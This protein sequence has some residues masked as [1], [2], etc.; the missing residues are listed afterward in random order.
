MK[1]GLKEY[2][3][4]KPKETYTVATYA[5]MKRGLKG[6]EI[7][8]Q[9]VVFYLVATYAP[10]KRGLKV[11]KNRFFS[12]SIFVATYAPMKRGL[13]EQQVKLPP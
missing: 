6:I 9:S 11:S 2:F 13:K 8:C 4:H 3:R 1:R 10:M 7:A 12:M 5:P